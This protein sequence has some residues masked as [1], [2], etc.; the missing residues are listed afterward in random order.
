MHSRVLLQCLPSRIAQS[1][2]C[3]TSLM[4][5][6]TSEMR[7]FRGAPNV[8]G[9]TCLSHCERNKIF[10]VAALAPN[11]NFLHGCSKTVA[12]RS[13]TFLPAVMPACLKN[14]ATPCKSSGTCTEHSR[15]QGIISFLAG[16]VVWLL[17]VKMNNRVV[18]YVFA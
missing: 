10:V 1:G 14:T 17:V 13:S 5:K 8:S 9:C 7:H 15:F 18:S 6:G 2:S 3:P 16:S 4:Q 12:F 11:V